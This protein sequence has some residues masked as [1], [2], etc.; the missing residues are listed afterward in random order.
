MLIPAQRKP[1]LRSFITAASQK[2]SNS[3]DKLN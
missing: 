3:I 2:I 1:D